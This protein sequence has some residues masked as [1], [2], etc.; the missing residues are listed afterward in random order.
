MRFDEFMRSALYASGAGYYRKR[1]RDPFGALGDFYT[2]SQIQPLFGRIIA[3]EAEALMPGAQILELG[4]GRGEMAEFFGSTYMGIEIGDDPP[5]S[6]SGFV[7]ANEFFDALPVRLATCMKGKRVEVIVDDNSGNFAPGP[8]LDEACESY[9]RR[10]CP[11]LAEGGRC[12]IGMEALTWID[13]IAGAMRSGYL[14]VIDYGYTTQ[15]SIRFPQGT[16]MSYLRHFPSGDVLA[17]PGNR[18]ITAHVAFDAL[19]DRATA[20]GFKCVRFET[21]R[22]LVLRAVERD[23]TLAGSFRARQ[24]LKTLL[25]GM[26]E[27]FR[28][29]LF[30]REPEK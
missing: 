29:L 8:A 22:Q 4:A 7:F 23:E 18:D 30:Q 11:F 27:T 13:R 5:S 24:H 28:C 10:Y 2:A 16:L 12:E 17:E 20:A 14:L 21:L 26:G 15:E 19:K 1:D 3:A 6:F 25:F 9:L